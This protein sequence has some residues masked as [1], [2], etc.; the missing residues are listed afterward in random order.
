MIGSE[1]VKTYLIF[2]GRT[3]S[4]G[5]GAERRFLR[6]FKKMKKDTN[7]DIELI[8]NRQ[9]YESAND[10]GFLDSEGLCN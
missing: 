2:S 8:T 5:G 7:I 6:L 9:L 3:L 4:G 10:L 1:F